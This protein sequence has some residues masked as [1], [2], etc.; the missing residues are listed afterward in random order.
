VIRI[1]TED[2][3]RSSS[4]VNSK[5]TS[6]CQYKNGKDQFDFTANDDS[7]IKKSPRTKLTWVTT[8]GESCFFEGKIE[9][10]KITEGT[11]TV[12]KLGKR[13]FEFNDFKDIEVKIGSAGK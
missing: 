8:C 6:D 12:T 2:C 13:L 5:H 11:L 9:I 1:D 7:S 4:W 3:L 10:S